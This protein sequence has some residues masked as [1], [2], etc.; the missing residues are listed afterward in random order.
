MKY[1][2]QGDRVTVEM[3]RDEYET[4]MLIVGAGVGSQ[5]RR[6]RGVFYRWLEFTNE[7][8]AGNPDYRPYEIP[9]G[10]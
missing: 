7:M 3:A 9:D 5:R 10:K 8:N 4:L 6:N 1:T 2:Q